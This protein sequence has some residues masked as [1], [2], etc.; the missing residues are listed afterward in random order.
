MDLL[1]KKAIKNLE[2]NGVEVILTEKSENALDAYSIVKDESIIVKSKSNTVGEI[3]L[4]KFLEGKGVQVVETDL[5]D[6][7]VQL[8]P[9]SKPSHP[10]A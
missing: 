5:G 8:D 10:I 2:K 7:I 1:V 4:S 3:G 9:D 6:R